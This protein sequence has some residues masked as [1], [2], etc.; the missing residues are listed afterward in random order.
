MLLEVEWLGCGDGTKEDRAV[1]MYHKTNIIGLQKFLW[2]KFPTWANNGNSVEDLWKNFKSIVMEGT[3]VS[4]PLKTLK[5]N[6][7]SE[8]YNK[9]VKRLK[10]KVRT[11]YSRRKQ[12]E[13]YIHELKQLYQKLLSAKRKAQETYLRSLLQNERNSWSEFYRNV[14]R[15]KGNK[16]T[17]PMIRDCN[18][19]LIT[20]HVEK[21]NI[22]HNYYASVFIHE[23]DIPVVNSSYEYEPFTVQVNTI[24]KRLALIERK[25][26]WDLTTS[27]GSYLNWVGK[28]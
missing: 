28:P 13:H 5:Q 25:N 10:R 23:R 15:R 22:L 17:I 11:A 2:E 1:P 26:R 12:G 8:F 9:E 19:E 6:P 4:V 21:A 27:L 24:R 18:E 14:K 7:D 16:E 20:D 3:G